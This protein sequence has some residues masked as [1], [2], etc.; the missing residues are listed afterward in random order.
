VHAAKVMGFASL[1][2]SY[3]DRRHCRLGHDETDYFVMP[4]HSRGTI[5]P[6]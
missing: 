2:P 5:A 3:D 1:Y 4:A 6:E